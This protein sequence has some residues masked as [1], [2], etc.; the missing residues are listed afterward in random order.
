MYTV[1]NECVDDVALHGRG[2]PRP[3]EKAVDI[4]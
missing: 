2:D 4:T 3:Y 1:L